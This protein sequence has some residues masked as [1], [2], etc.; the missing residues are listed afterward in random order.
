MQST[1]SM[2]AASNNSVKAL[3]MQVSQ[4]ANQLHEREKGGV[5]ILKEGHLYLMLPLNRPITSM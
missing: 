3:E 5:P 4:L 1:Q 2:F